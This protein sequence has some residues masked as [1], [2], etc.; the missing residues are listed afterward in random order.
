MLFK[1]TGSWNLH[2]AT[3]GADLSH[4]NKTASPLDAQTGCA[5][6]GLTWATCTG[7]GSR[8]IRVCSVVAK[9]DVLP[10]VQRFL[11]FS[12]NCGLPLVLSISSAQ[13][14]PPHLA[15][16]NLYVWRG[17]GYWRWDRK[18]WSRGTDQRPATSRIHPCKPRSTVAL[19]CQICQVLIK[20]IYALRW[21][22][23]SL[24]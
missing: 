24:L 18:S 5:V 21:K 7:D 20:K 23:P 14:R 13:S 22:V 11:S 15:Q 2:P 19:Y 8:P 9:L 3:R 4:I 1:T 16:W 17:M 10:R 6:C 12:Q